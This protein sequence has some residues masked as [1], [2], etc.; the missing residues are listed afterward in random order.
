M[1]ELTCPV[2][3]NRISFLNFAKAPTP[4][5]LKCKQCKSKLRLKKYR[6]L[7]LGVGL[8]IGLSIGILAKLYL[9]SFRSLL[10][11]V[12][13]G[14]IVFEIIAYVVLRLLKV[15]LEQRN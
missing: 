5:H 14:A 11:V 1:N 10:G 4:F 6:G 13:L 15:D 8:T 12:C 3:Q 7:L 9:L 2:C